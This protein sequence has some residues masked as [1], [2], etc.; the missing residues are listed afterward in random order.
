MTDLEE[1]GR[2]IILLRR[3]QGLTQE[4]TAFRANLSVSRLQTIEYGCRNTTVDTLIRIAGALGVD[5][6]V[7]G[8]F[9]RT[10]RAVL[11]EFRRF[12]RLPERG[13]GLLQ[14]CGNIVLLR[15][16]RGLTQKQLAYLAGISTVCL[17][18][19]ERECANVTVNKLLCVAGAF[20]MSLME[21][22]SL[23]MPEETLMD[24]IYSARTR[25]GIKRK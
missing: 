2:N 11:S 8:I 25:A 24:M 21:L 18:D 7:F 13:G 9:S 19:I 23:T 4:E 1:I 12:P 3:E 22:S 5:P 6:R 10:D 16:K 17:R 20:H 15:K 14:I